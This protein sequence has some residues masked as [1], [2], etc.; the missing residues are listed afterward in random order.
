MWFF[1][2][3][4]IDPDISGSDMAVKK[5]SDPYIIRASATTDGWAAGVAS[6]NVT[7]TANIDTGLDSLRREVLYV[8]A[9][10]FGVTSDDNGEM[11]RDAHVATTAVIT[12]G[13]AS[14]ESCRFGTRMQLNKSQVGL[15]E[16]LS[17]DQVLGFDSA[18]LTLS[19]V[20]NPAGSNTAQSLLDLQEHR[21]P[22]TW[23]PNEPGVPLGIVTDSTMQF[24]VNQFL[25]GVTSAGT[26]GGVT[27]SI[28][29]IAQRMQSDASL[30]AAILTGN[31]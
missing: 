19:A 9:C 20:E 27:G 25:D 29:I 22:E 24:V 26:V 21:F 11:Q 2:I 14:N 23:D 1:I 12:G 15:I 8:W 6:P 5:L 18:I 30:Y 17:N 16:D 3:L 4:L 28:K 10:F 31:Q 13:G 7:A